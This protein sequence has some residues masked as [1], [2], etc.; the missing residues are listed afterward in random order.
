MDVK[1]EYC[2]RERGGREGGKSRLQAS[3][4]RFIRSV[5]DKQRNED[6]RD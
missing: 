1:P 5:A 6:I 4:M 2:V 3:E